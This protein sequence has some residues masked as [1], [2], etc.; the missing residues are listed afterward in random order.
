MI[1]WLIFESFTII[2]RSSSNLMHYSRVFVQGVYLKG[3]FLREPIEA[4]S[5]TLRSVPF[6]YVLECSRDVVG[7]DG[8][9][10]F[11][12]QIVR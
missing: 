12:N 1:N 7:A 9:Q 10:R 5:L 3:S 8:R 11:M 2:W 4:L 6:C